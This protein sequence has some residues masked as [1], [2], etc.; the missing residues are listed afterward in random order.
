MIPLSGSENQPS[1]TALSHD[2]VGTGKGRATPSVATTWFE[3]IVA[4][5]GAKPQSNTSGYWAA[6]SVST[7][8]KLL[9]VTKEMVFAMQSV[10]FAPTL[11]ELPPAPPF[12]PATACA[13]QE[14]RQIAPAKSPD[15]P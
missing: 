1:K 8:E 12:P 4:Y 10:P 13:P 5:D 3:A 9:W 7:Y 11:P 2:A 6:T 14:W 15:V